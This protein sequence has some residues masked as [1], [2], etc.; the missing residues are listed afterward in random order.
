MRLPL[1]LLVTILV[2]ASGSSQQNSPGSTAG[3]S[4]KQAAQGKAA[5]T[6]V[7][8]SRT[9]QAAGCPLAMDAHLSSSAVLS[10]AEKQHPAQGPIQHIDVD[11]SN[12]EPSEVVSV[13]AHVQGISAAPR[14]VPL[15]EF[16]LPKSNSLPPPIPFHADRVLPIG[17]KL[18]L[19][20]TLADATGVEWVQLDRITYANGS[21][22]QRQQ[23]DVCKVEPSRIMR[24]N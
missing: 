8:L 13:D 1:L 18:S 11:L 24:V 5:S 4:L 15:S 22:W 21:T 2:A 12:T 10:R 9:R 7:I 14:F 20:W 19:S 23:A 3:L 17:G 16:N 6:A